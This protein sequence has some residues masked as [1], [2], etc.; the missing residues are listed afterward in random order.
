MRD[1]ATALSNPFMSQSDAQVGVK[2]DGCAGRGWNK[3]S[4]V[5]SF[6]SGFICGAAGAACQVEGASFWSCTLLSDAVC[7]GR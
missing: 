6:P 3:F 7:L 4:D 2:R 5:M 1:S